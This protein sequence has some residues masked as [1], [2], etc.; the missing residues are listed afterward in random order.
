MTIR[1][2]FFG[3]VFSKAA[4]LSVFLAVALVTT[5]AL[6]EGASLPVLPDVDPVTQ[7]L[8]LI[9][10]WKTG[11]VIGAGMGIVVLLG[12]LAKQFLPEGFKF[13]RLLVVVLSCVY[14]VLASIVQGTPPLAAI[15]VILVTSGGAMAL[16]EAL[17]GA[18]ILKAKAQA[19]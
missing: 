2:R 9:A 1:E 19:G 14:G 3:G 18:G 13:K 16:Y 11:G 15:L 6:A 7:I 4:V 10:N 5:R 12:Q 8:S 17:K